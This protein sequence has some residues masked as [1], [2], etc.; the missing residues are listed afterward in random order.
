MAEMGTTPPHNT[1]QNNPPLKSEK[2]PENGLL[3]KI[4]TIIYSG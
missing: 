4:L 2:H 3:G 1:S